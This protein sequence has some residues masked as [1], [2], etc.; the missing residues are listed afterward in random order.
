MHY[1]FQALGLKKY[2]LQ[3]AWQQRNKTYTLHV[4][5]TADTQVKEVLLVFEEDMDD[6]CFYASSVEN[7][8][9]V[10]SLACTVSTVCK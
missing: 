6:S 5:L 8:A 2:S 7:N 9:N 1:R 10:M 3:K 4:L